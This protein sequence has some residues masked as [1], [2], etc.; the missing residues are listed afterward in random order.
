MTPQSPESLAEEIPELRPLDAHNQALLANVHPPD[1]TNP[2]PAGR[3][4]LVVLGAG[5]AGLVTAA[6]AAGLGAKVALVENKLLGGDCLNVG[7]VPSKALLRAARAW[8]DVRDAGQYGVRVPPG[9]AVAFPAVMERMR[10]LRAEISPHDSAGR[11]QSLG[12]DV[13]LGA[14][15]FAG[16]DALEVGGRVLR[17]RRAVVATG[18][19]AA[20]PAIPGLAEAGFL[21]NE[22]VFSLTD[23]PPR[24][25]VIGAGPLGCELAQAFARFGSRVFLIGNQPQIMPREDADAAGVV[26]SALRRDGVTL[27]LGARVTRVETAAAEKVLHLAGGQGPVEVR[28]DAILVGVGRAPNVEGLNLEGAGVQYDPRDGVHVNDRLQTTNKRI[29]AA[30]DVCSRYKFT[31]AAD[32]LARVAIQNALFLGRAKASA[33]VIPWCTYTD[34]E[35]AHVGLSEKE[36]TVRGVEVQTLIEPLREVDRAVLDGEAEGFVKVHLRQGTDRIVG[37]TVVARHAGEM[38]S[39]LTLAVVGRLGLRTLARTIHP[40]PTQAE[41][42]KKVADAYNRTRLTP[43]VKWLLG[44]WLTWTR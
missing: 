15:R 19:R 38:I 30:G 17:F 5:T 43:W 41:A 42:I 6:G 4:N 10:R 8:A 12:V 22:T 31:H 35:V 25:A 3:Y 7:C 20:V 11:F 36:A 39:E 16:P 2:E 18:A 23:L 21:T 34:P 14:G 29:Y 32:A 37:A 13:F 44:K 9:A 28:V 27:V 40:Y 26:A 24:L 33:L 1:W